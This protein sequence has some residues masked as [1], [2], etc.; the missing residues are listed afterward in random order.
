MESPVM[1]LSCA[2][3]AESHESLREHG[4]GTKKHSSIITVTRSDPE[5][6]TANINTKFFF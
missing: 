6:D 1:Q 2:R 5:K 4:G 3:T